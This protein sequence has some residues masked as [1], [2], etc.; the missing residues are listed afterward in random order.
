MMYVRLYHDFENPFAHSTHRMW[1]IVQMALRYHT[2]HPTIATSPKQSELSLSSEQL[3]LDLWSKVGMVD[4]LSESL[5]ETESFYDSWE[6]E[7][8]LRS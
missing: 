5:S 8:I 4:T 2:K 7:V 3:A 6:G 1:Y